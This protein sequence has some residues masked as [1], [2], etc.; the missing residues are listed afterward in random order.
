MSTAG[1]EMIG[2][3]CDGERFFVLPTGKVGATVRVSGAVYT[4]AWWPVFDADGLDVGAKKVL[5]A[6]G[7]AVPVR[8][9]R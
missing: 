9:R 1:Y 4:W 2:G 6:P 7:V 5:I 8:P 3:P